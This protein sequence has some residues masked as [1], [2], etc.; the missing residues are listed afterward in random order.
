MAKT[1]NKSKKLDFIVSE[2]A[3]LKAAIKKLT[4]AHKALAS[5]ITL[6]VQRDTPKKKPKPVAPAAKT[7]ATLAR[8]RPVIVKL[9]EAAEA[10]A[11]T[12]AK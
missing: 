2:I 12:S 4:K 6:A 5:A 8:K 10:K 3:D 1:R 7:A 9:A 11:G